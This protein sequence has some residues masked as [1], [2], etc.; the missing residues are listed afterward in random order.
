MLWLPSFQTGCRKMPMF[1]R[2]QWSLD[3]SR[4]TFDIGLIETNA[5][6]FWIRKGPPG[7]PGSD[8]HKEW[9]AKRSDGAPGASQIPPAPTPETAG[10]DLAQIIDR[11]NPESRSRIDQYNQ[12][13]AAK[14]AQRRTLAARQPDRRIGQRSLPEASQQFDRP[15]RLR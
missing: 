3:L 1:E 13:Q 14:Q 8:H 12:K 10:G 2:R 11:L 7:Q 15:V 6:M 4:F 9:I 5:M